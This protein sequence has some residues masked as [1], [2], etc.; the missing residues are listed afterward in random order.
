MA[1]VY[2]K[3]FKMIAIHMY[4]TEGKSAYA[5]A[6]ELGLIDKS[7]VKGWLRT[8]QKYG[9]AGFDI[10]A[11]LQEQQSHSFTGQSPVANLE[12]ENLLLKA[13]NEYLK[14]LLQLEGWDVLKRPNSK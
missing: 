6:K 7:Y 5:I 3:E 14:K 11:P 1:R 12:K 4:Y 2:S 13:E 10:K 8:Y 9:E